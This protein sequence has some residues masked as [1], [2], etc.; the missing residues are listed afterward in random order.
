MKIEANLPGPVKD[1]KRS[2]NRR[3]TKLLGLK[4]PDKC[5][6]GLPLAM[7]GGGPSLNDRLEDLRN[8]PGDVWV[9]CGAFQY[10]LAQGIDGVFF[11]VDPQPS[12]APM[13]I[14]A[15]KAVVS[16]CNDPS[17]LDTLEQSGADI[18]VFKT[19]GMGGSGTAVTLV[20]VLGLMLEYPSISFFGCD[21]SYK[22]RT[23]SYANIPYGQVLKVQVGDEVFTT[24]YPL[25]SQ[26]V[27]LSKAMRWIPDRLVNESG[28]LLEA[29]VNS[30][31]G[32]YDIIALN[33]KEAMNIVDADGRP[34][35]E[36][37]RIVKY[38]GA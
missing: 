9:V 37:H 12:A 35:H 28:G 2:R 33:Y 27:E 25:L 31:D 22:D 20:P 16:T 30:E 23:H 13:C 29:L 17:V 7:V 10:C 32:D 19:G 38:T 4:G 11:N 34:L 18:R 21:G 14:G 8:W 1:G 5:G 6:N 24:S 36:T 3:Y 15:K 26:A